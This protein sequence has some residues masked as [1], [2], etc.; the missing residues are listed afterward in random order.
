MPRRRQQLSL[1][2][3]TD[4]TNVE[5]PPPEKAVLQALAELLLE[6]H[7][8]DPIA[9]PDDVVPRGTADER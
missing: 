5:E 1:A 2:L 7:G 4:S 3:E 6:A 8:Q 9:D